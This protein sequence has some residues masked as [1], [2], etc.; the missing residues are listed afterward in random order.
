[1]S[2]DTATATA[3]SEKVEKLLDEIGNLSL[4][5]AAEL[6]DAFKEKFGVTA[7]AAPM[8]MPMGMMP[9]GP[10]APAEE[11]DEEPTSFNVI[12]KE[13]GGQKIQVIKKVRELT[14]LGL[15]EAKDLVESA[16]KEVKEGISKEEAE[17]AAKALED[18]GATAEVKGV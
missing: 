1:M 2:E 8:A 13:I 12:L 15:K 4:F 6:A 9:G 14:S 16:P 7:A 18:A 17:E 5:E 3:P 11:E 10:A